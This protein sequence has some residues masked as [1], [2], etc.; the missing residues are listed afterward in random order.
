[1]N[2]LYTV[3]IV[4]NAIEFDVAPVAYRSTIAITDTV[5]QTTTRQELFYLEFNLSI[6]YQELAYQTVDSI[7]FTH[8]RTAFKLKNIAKEDSLC[9]TLFRQFTIPSFK[10]AARDQ[11]AFLIQFGLHVPEGSY[12]YVIELHSGDKSGQRQD[13]V[14]LGRDN[15]PISDLLIASEIVAD[16][17]ASSLRKGNLKVTPHPSAVFDERYAVLFL[18]YE[19]YDIVPDTTELK[20]SYII[21]DTSGVAVAKIPRT[22]QKKF[23]SQA[24]N[25][26]LPIQGLDPGTYTLAVVINDPTTGKTVRKDASF[27]VEGGS[28]GEV[29]YEGL[30]YYDRIEYLTDESQYKQFK[31]LP[32]E[33]KKMFLRKFWETHD[34]YAFAERF[35]YA[36]SQYQQGYKVGSKTDRGRIY[37]KYGKPDEIER[38]LLQIEESK[39]Y[40]IWRYYTGDEFIFVDVRGTNEYTLVWTNQRREPSQPTLYKHLPY[41]IRERIE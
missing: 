40:E 27:S 24:M 25:F 39:P 13:V 23:S 16:T 21:E 7:I 18:Y 33:G 35:E 11:I 5:M 9:D 1:M 20:I 34:Y 2:I 10:M 14:E 22:I 4:C 36:E 6:P 32:D 8:V 17:T 28:V 41:D 3:L 38:S 31:S 19:M 29:S 30:A 15:Y 26:G 37:I 12:D